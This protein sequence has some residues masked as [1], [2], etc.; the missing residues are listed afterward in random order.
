MNY[1][2]IV[3]VSGYFFIFILM[4]IFIMNGMFTLERS[5]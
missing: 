4:K 2:L 3:A 1:Q 5:Y